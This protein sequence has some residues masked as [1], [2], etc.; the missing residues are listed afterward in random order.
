MKMY[1]KE[2]LLDFILACLAD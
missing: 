2:G 1:T